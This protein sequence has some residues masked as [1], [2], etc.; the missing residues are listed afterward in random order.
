MWY[1]DVDGMK[2]RLM[3]TFFIQTKMKGKTIRG[4]FATLA[5]NGRLYI[6]KGALWNGADIIRD[7]E[8]VMRES[9]AH[10]IGCAWFLKGLIDKK[11]RGQFDD[12]FDDLLQKQV[13]RDN[14]SA[15]RKA[16]ISKSVKAATWA[17]YG[18]S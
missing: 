11:M 2:Y 14:M 13:D 1:E 9:L 6:L 8:N 16:Y 10:D 4:S 17:H 3:K 5:K 15:L 7:T 18:I 12:L